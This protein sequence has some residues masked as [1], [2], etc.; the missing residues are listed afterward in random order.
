MDAYN[1]SYDG[2][3]AHRAVLVGKLDL[4]GLF[5][6]F[7]SLHSKHSGALTDVG[8]NPPSRCQC[9]NLPK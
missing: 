1:P 8:V 2:R 6:A 5:R 7:L 4:S 3:V 9:S